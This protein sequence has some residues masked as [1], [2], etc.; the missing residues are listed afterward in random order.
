MARFRNHCTKNT[1]TC[2]QLYAW[3]GQVLATFAS[4]VFLCF[5]NSNLSN[6]WSSRR[7]VKIK[8]VQKNFFWLDFETKLHFDKDPKVIGI[9]QPIITSL[10]V[11]RGTRLQR[12]FKF[13]EHLVAVSQGGLFS[14]VFKMRLKL[15]FFSWKVWWNRESIWRGAQVVKRSY[16]CGWNRTFTWL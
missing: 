3:C 15:I 9:A 13:C 6:K 12:F 14:E 7:S 4:Q 5:E 8:V 11:S 10:K 1:F 16:R 2:I